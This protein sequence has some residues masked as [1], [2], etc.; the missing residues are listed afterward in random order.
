M[1]WFW[2]D[3]LARVLVDS[4]RVSGERVQDWISTPVAI[5]FADGVEA[6]EAAIELADVEAT[7]VA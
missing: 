7:Q 2:T 4:G 5:A 3:D 6:I 1:P